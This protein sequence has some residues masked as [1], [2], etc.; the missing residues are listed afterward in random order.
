[1]KSPRRAFVLGTALALIPI[2]VLLIF[3][4]VRSVTAGSGFGMQAQH[5][6][7][8]FYLAQSGLEIGFHCFQAENF[9]GTTHE[10]D[11]SATN[12][13]SPTLLRADAFPG[14]T[15]DGAGWYA[16]RWDPG[17]P[18][19]DSYTHSGLPERFRFQ[20]MYPAP[21]FFRLVCEASVGSRTNT[22]QVEGTLE[23]GFNY[24]VFDNGDLA[25][26]THSN[27]ETITGKIHANGN[28]YMR[29]YKTEGLVALLR[30]V[31]DD[32]DPELNIFT[33][34]MTA[35]GNVVRHID[36]WDQADD[37]G[38]VRL[39]NSTTSKSNL[40]EGHAQGQSGQGNAYD[41]Y[42]PDWAD[43]GTSGALSRWDSAVADKTLGAKTRS[44]PSRKAFLPGGYYEQKADLKID[45]GSAAAWIH[46][47]TF[48][49]EAEER[50]V[51]VK[52]IDVE[53][54]AAAGAWPSN[55]LMHSAVPI[56]LING[57][58]LAGPLTV[59][60]A[61]TIYVKGDFNKQFPNA[62]SKSAGV[63]QMQP[64]A[65]MTTD[66][67]Y[68]LTGDYV[69]HTTPTYPTVVDLALGSGFPEATDGESYPG[70][71]VDTLEI[72]GALVDGAPTTDARAWINDPANPYWISGT[73][74]DNPFTGHLDRKVKQLPSS[75]MEVR[76][77]YPQSD[78]YLENMQKVRVRT[79]GAVMHL[80]VADMASFDN[81][82]ADQMITP[83]IEKSY[84]IP[85]DDDIGGEPG[86]IFSHDPAMATP[87]GA[88]SSV[89][90]A[91]VVA[92]RTRWSSH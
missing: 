16:W 59:T 21:G 27:S 43:P 40:F 19:G 63:A 32:T 58:E 72:N 61:S 17:D 85:P 6:A 26:F 77:V 62:A 54:M 18:L 73:G 35:G 60:S 69:D 31:F 64:A 20:V 25:D 78:D 89:P 37:G 66:R 8:A 83:W 88:M 51:T 23:S 10:P 39:T 11:G 67:I 74:I 87:A 71:E 44:A 56:R 14:L 75:P 86:V 68:K 1:M 80:R 46:D 22:Q 49:N 42:H 38:T 9:S 47:T 28:L 5:K 82:N 34:S 12:S 84:Y 41:S 79:I 65:L 15:R 76:V 70:D 45:S 90:F 53:G 57:E 33:D 3:S 36:P 24:V 4:V 30:T 13:A 2:G 81:S 7:R 50:S 52:E 48:Y 55:G 92:R 91:P 29:P